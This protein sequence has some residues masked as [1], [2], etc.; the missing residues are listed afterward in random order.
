MMLVLCMQTLG[1]SD[2]TDT[3]E[4]NVTNLQRGKSA[5]SAPL[6]MSEISPPGVRTMI[7]IR[8]RSEENSKIPNTS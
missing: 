6:M 2:L 5:L 1:A 3:G 7:P 4:E 8:L